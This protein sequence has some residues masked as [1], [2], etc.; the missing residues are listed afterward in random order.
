MMDDS[1]RTAHLMQRVLLACF[2][3]ACL[4]PAAASGMNEALAPSPAIDFTPSYDSLVERLQGDGFDPSYLNAAFTDHRTRFLPDVLYINL[5]SKY[6]DADYS[7]YASGAS[8]RQARQFLREESAY[9]D[10]LEKQFQVHKEVIVSILYIESAFGKHA[11][12]N[13]VF[14]VFSTLAVATAPEILSAAADRIAGSYPRMSREEIEQRAQK[15]AAW[16][17]QELKSLLTIA[18]AQS[19]DPLSIRG[20]W[21]GAFGMSQF[22]PSSYVQFARDGNDDGTISLHDRY[23]AMTSVATYLKSH[24]WTLNATEAQQMAIIRQYNNSGAYSEAVL[25]LA[26][27]IEENG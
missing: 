6:R 16:A 22:L 18:R 17:Y 8:V 9:L 24:G 21:A 3:T 4:V 2:L 5:T 19:I 23:D 7:R 15:K 27:L 12:S 10:R 20:S 13:V 14:N 25:Q 11:G 26:R 1:M